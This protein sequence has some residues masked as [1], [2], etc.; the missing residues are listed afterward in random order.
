LVIGAG[1]MRLLWRNLLWFIFSFQ[2]SVFSFQFSVFNFKTS[3]KITP[4][5]N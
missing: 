3:I 1:A 5:E 4:T 2:F